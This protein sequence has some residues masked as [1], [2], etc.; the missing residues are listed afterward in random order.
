MTAEYWINQLQLLPHP[1]GGFYKEMYRSAESISKN[2]LPERYSGNR[3]FGTSIYFLLRSEDISSFH[4]ITSDEL[5]FFHEGSA[6]SV[7]VIENSRLKTIVLGKNPE[8]GEVLQCTIPT[9]CWFGAKVNEQNSYSLVS[10]TVSPG[11]DFQDFELAKREELVT[12]FPHLKEIIKTLT[13]SF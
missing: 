9:N 6:V 4:K 5:W 8:K 11:F 3:N 7:Y 1:E 10:C 13:P 2:A 12:Q